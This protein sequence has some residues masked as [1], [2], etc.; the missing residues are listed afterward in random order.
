MSYDPAEPGPVRGSDAYRAGVAAFLDAF[1]G[2]SARI[3][4]QLKE[5][6]KVVT[7]WTVTGRHEGELFGLPPT[8]REVTFTG[9]DIHRVENGCVVE[10]WTSWDT[11]RLMR[12]L[13]LV[14]EGA[15]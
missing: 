13:G 9:I 1:R 3:E 11:L 12:Q 6:T 4:D 14:P 15:Q 2:L 5:G 8:G 10:E 7:R